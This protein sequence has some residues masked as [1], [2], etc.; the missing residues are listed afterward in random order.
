MSGLA[1][2][3]ENYRNVAERVEAAARRAGREVTLLAAVKY[4]D[5]EHIRYLH[6]ELGVAD[7]GEN[8]AQQ[9][10]EHAEALTDCPEIRFHFIGKLQANKAKYVAEHACMLHSL[11]SLKLAAELQRQLEKRGKELDVLVEINSGGEENKSGVSPA[12]AAEL[13]LGL[14]AFPRLKLRGFMTMAPKCEK[15]EEYRK[16]FRETF[17][18]GIDIWE[19]KLHNIGRPLFSMGM[20]ES[21]DVAIEEGADLIRVG[22]ALFAEPE[23]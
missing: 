2:M 5:A 12:E 7:M 17:D 13:C 10:V 9:L 15:K 4:T 19:K 16:Y 20:S 14:S 11:D 18:L 23:A 6:R 3:D 22:R 8:R 1:Y 21:F